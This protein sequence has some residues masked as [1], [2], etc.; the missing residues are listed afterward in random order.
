VKALKSLLTQGVDPDTM[1]KAGLTAIYAAVCAHRK[2]AVASLIDSGANVNAQYKGGPT[3]L[4]WAIFFE[5]ADVA[6]LLVDA[7]ADVNLPKNGFPPLTQTIWAP[8]WKDGKDVI[9]YLLSHGADMD[10][11]DPTGCTPLYMAAFMGSKEVLDPFLARLAN[12]GTI[13]M[14]ACR[15]DLAAVKRLVATGTDPN[16]KDEFGCAPLHWAV[17]G[18]RNEVA[19]FLI[20][21]GASL[22]EY[23][24][25]G[26]PPVTVATRFDMVRLLVSRGADVNGAMSG[27]GR[28]RLHIACMTGKLDV[29]KFLVANGADVNVKTHGGQTPLSI[30]EER[31]HTEIVAILTKASEGQAGLEETSSRGEPPDPR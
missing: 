30:A 27:N 28:T 23:N 6:R 29:V 3:P 25:M 4:V 21:Q 14:A 7:D 20:S 31:G 16:A 17:A 22:N 24:N 2:D 12:P 11:K 15:G 26:C 1:D 13:H 9:E 18:E 10:Q 8:R 19:D 5:D